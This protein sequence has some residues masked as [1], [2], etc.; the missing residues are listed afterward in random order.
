MTLGLN[1]W[2]AITLLALGIHNLPLAAPGFLNVGYNIYSGRV[3]GW[4][5]AGI[6]IVVNVGLWHWVTDIPG[7]RPEF[8]AVSGVR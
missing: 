3:M 8:R 7:E 5:I 2:L 1:A 4:A 6:A